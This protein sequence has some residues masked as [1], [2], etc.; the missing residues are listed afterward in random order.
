MTKIFL[1]LAGVVCVGCLILGCDGDESPETSA[2]PMEAPTT[3]PTWHADIFPVVD[4]ACNGCH[5]GGGVAPFPLQTYAEFSG[6]ASVSFDSIE[7]GRMP[8]WK[9]DRACRTYR[10]ER[11]LTA[12]E[13]A[14]FAA[15]QEAGM[16]EGEAV[17]RSEDPQ[18]SE[19]E[20]DMVASP[21]APYIA[22]TEV[23]DDYRCF[24]LDTTF[25]EDT[26][27]RRARI[28]PGDPAIVHHVLVYVV[29]PDDIPELEALD[30]GEDGLGYTC[31]GGPRVPEFGVP[32]PIAGWAPG[33]VPNVYLEGSMAYIPQ[34]SRLVMQ[35]HYNLIAAD[36]SPDLTQ[37]EF[38]VYDEAQP[39]VARSKPLPNLWIGIPAGE[40]ESVQVREFVNYGSK[41]LTVV[42]TAPHMHTLGTRIRVDILAPET[43]E[44]TCLVEI[45]DWDFN[46]Q[47]TFI[48]EEP[49]EVPP[50]GR[51]KM[52]C[53]Y[54]NSA[55]NQPL[56]DGERIEPRDVTWGDGTLDEMC[57][58][59]VGVL[60]PFKNY[61]TRC[62]GVA[63]CQGACP[64][65]D[66][67][68]ALDCVTADGYCAQCAVLAFT[69][70]GGCIRNDCPFQLYEARICMLECTIESL[71]GGGMGACMA[72]KCPAQMATLSECM[73]T[74]VS[75]GACDENL[76]SCQL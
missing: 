44:E 33:G 48:L 23:T 29:Y 35:V 58:N 64:S 63:A 43:D 6:V 70:E 11:V 69:N 68:C 55:G 24:V 32:S 25:A 13:K 49:I 12:D 74:A 75:Q 60:E 47:Q 51:F 19:V 21:D 39:F 7:H 72:D 1:R 15:W 20:P 10:E 2:M 50:G 5:Y 3:G 36:P 37:V 73:E 22:N 54:D 40:S 31:Y 27:I 71:L 56:V 61:S 52:T 65:G 41:P 28:V 42:S 34:G 53:V 16:P 76:R 17:E 66:L 67:A 26:F 45:P 30:S 62:G 8:P 59:F 18:L 38:N 4:R 57:L 14:L 46:W 9:P